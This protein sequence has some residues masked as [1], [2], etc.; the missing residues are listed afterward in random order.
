MSGDA[1]IRRLSPTFVAVGT[2]VTW[3]SLSIG[4]GIGVAW[5][6]DGAVTPVSVGALMLLCVGLVG[7]LGVAVGIV[8]SLHGWAR[9]LVVPWLLL[10]MAT[11]YSLSIAL[12]ATY[13]A[14][15]DGVAAAPEGLDA[16]HVVMT[17]ADGVTLTGWYVPSANGAAVVVRHGSGSDRASALPQ[18]RVL[19]ENGYGVLLVD[20][21]GHGS[22]GGRAMDLGWYGDLDTAAA[23][24]LL[25]SRPDV[26][27][28]RIAVL[29]MSM[30]GEEAIGAAA[31][32]PRLAAVVA[33]GVTGRT[34]ADK[35]WLSEEYG[36]AGQ[37]QEQ[38]DRLTYALVG[39]LAGA[40]A[41]TS[42]REAVAAAPTPTLLIAAGEVP[43]EGHV[44][45]RLAAAAAD[46]VQVWV[47]PGAGHTAALATQP[48]E[49][50]ERVIG[51]LDAHLRG[52]TA[53][54]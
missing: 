27:P 37:L 23:V 29:G 38:L 40:P 50:E 15:G 13:V 14:P 2:F 10:V 53:N 4:V 35:A 28:R 16:V 36:L 45:R 21:R 25:V 7:L 20:A 22:S 42:L 18:A 30:G 12:A 5:V 17:S 51:F 46:S 8:R 33:E 24:D 31:A 48:D 6:L 1:R 41:P 26:D 9:L 49:W 43:D 34:A 19:A 54:G 39:L 32:D 52:P 44:A 3:V 11:T 47:V